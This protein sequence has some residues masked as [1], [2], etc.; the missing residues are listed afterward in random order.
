MVIPGKKTLKRRLNE[1]EILFGTFY[2]FNDAHLVEMLGLAGFDFII[3]D[4]EHAAYGYNEMQDTVRAA[5]G[6]GMDAV[7]R[8]PSGLPEHVLHA[9]DLG[10]QGVQ[11]PSLRDA[12]DARMVVDNMRFFPVGHRGFGTTTRAARYTFGDTQAFLDYSNN[13]LLCVIMVERLQ[14]VEQLEEL[15]AIPTV[16]VLFIG[17]GDLSQEV[18]KPGQTGCKEVLDIARKITDTALARGKIVGMYCA[19]LAD[20][21][22]AIGWG[23]KYIAFSAELNMIAAKFRETIASLHGLRERKISG[24]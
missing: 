5:N 6:V 4:G 17:A 21:E 1:G 23:M 12:A 15:C 22:R 11:V 10:A 18:G 2:K 16:D 19:T 20:V 3:V 24:T 9:C 8:V 13:E 14:M 7:V